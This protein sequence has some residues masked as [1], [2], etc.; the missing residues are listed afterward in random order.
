MPPKKED[1]SKGGEETLTRIA[2]VKEDRCKPKKCRQECKKFCP[3]VKTGKLCIEVSP[4]SIMTSISEELCIGCGICVKKCPFDAI[5]IINLPKN[6]VS[7]T[8]HRYGPN[9]FK[10]HR[11]PMPRPGQVLGLVG[12]NGIGKS[13]ALKVLSGKLKPNLGRF[14]SPPDWKEVLQYFRGSEL[15][16]YFNRVLEDNLIAVIKPQFVDNIP[17]AVRGNVRQILEKRAEKETYPL[18]DLETLLQVLDLAQVCDRNVENLS[19]GELQRFAIAMSA[20]QRADVYMMDE[21]SSYLDVNQRLKAA[22][23]IRNLLDIQKYVVVVEHDLSV[24]DYLSDFICCLYGKPGVYGVV[25]LPFSVRE[26]INIFLDGFVPTEN[27]RFRDESLSFKM[28]DQD[29]DQE[30]KKFALNQYPHLVKVQG[31][32]TLNVEAGEFTDSEIVV[33]LGENGTGKTTFIRMLAG[34]MP[35]DDAEEPL[36]KYNV[37][38]KPQKINPKFQGDVR[39]LLHA[40]IRN[41]MINPQFQG[42]VLKPLNIEQL[43]DYEVQNLSGGEL[44]RVA[45]TLC[46]GQPADIYL[47]DEPSAYLDSEQRILA[48]KVIKRFIMHTKK[49][50]FIVEHDFIMSSY[51]ADTVIVYEGTPS[52]N[53][54][55]RSP[56]PLQTGMNRFLKNLDIT[57]RRDPTNFRPRINKLHSTKDREQKEAGTYYYMEEASISKGIKPAAAAATAASGPAK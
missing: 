10:L 36:P 38:Y 23:V 8:T 4:T 26:G 44:Q 19:G 40:K 24:L 21:P 41:N 50:A 31:N 27:L 13:T 14:D 57:F 42:D 48:S 51:L 6:L 52:K 29:S 1:K 37:S 35:S 32:F 12:T 3:V 33:M 49:T 55:A 18:E 25:T 20:I 22:K 17:K 56:Q 54:V 46:L 30:I 16:N 5:N 9:T 28:A 7:E 11:L 43:Y 45:I 34:L 47:I 53:A 2:I 15:Q 39:S